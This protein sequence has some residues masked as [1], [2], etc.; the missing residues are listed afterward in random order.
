MIFLN[1][2]FKLTQY[3]F[4]LCQIGGL[5]ETFVDIAMKFCKK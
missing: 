2:H 5:L 4:Q 3:Q 1:Y